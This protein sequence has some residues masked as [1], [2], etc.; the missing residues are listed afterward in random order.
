MSSPPAPSMGEAVG[1][2]RDLR[3]YRGTLSGLDQGLLDA[4]V[5]AGLQESPDETPAKQIRPLWYAYATCPTS[6]RLGADPSRDADLLGWEQAPWTLTHHSATGGEQEEDSD[7]LE[8]GGSLLSMRRSV[9]H[10]GV[11][12]DRSS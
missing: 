5:A 11:A 12:G 3:C 10:V 9:W 7:A 8:G 4:L 2:L 6:G 1:F